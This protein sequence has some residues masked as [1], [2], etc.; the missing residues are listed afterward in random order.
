MRNIIS[1]VSI[2]KLRRN[3]DLHSFWLICTSFNCNQVT[4]L[5]GHPKLAN[6][7]LFNIDSSPFTSLPVENIGNLD[8]DHT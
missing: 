7:F 1:S 6:F 8:T 2:Q 3:A 5:L 4:K